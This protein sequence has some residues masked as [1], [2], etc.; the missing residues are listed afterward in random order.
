[1][2]N[3]AEYRVTK[4]EI[5]KLK[6]AGYLVTQIN[7]LELRVVKNGNVYNICYPSDFPF[8][9]C[10]IIR[11]NKDFIYRDW[12]PNTNIVKLLEEFD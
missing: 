1:M 7:P 3:H 8:K 2:E 4:Y 9:P 6:D 5:P 10:V 11:D 12:L